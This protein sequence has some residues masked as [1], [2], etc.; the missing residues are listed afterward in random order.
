MMKQRKNDTR[1]QWLNRVATALRPTFKKHGF[2]LPPVRISTGFTSSGRRGAAA[3]EC[4][5]DK[6]DADR[7]HQIFIDPRDD[8]PVNVVNSVAHELIHAAIGLEQGH[9]GDFKKLALAIGML[10]PMTET[11]SGPEFVALAG[12]ILA[13]VGAYPHKRLECGREL[14][15][16]FAAA[17]DK[18]AKPGE[19]K[20]TK[21]GKDRPS[22]I[23]T[24]GPKPQGARLKKAHCPACGYTV[25]ITRKWIEVAVPSCPNPGCEKHGADLEVAD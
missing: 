4:W 24:S 22:T 11:P 5:T 18:P 23:I 2:P 13:K 3:A 6:L 20:P 10:E 19:T 9:K 16:L 21:P 14:G 25:R 8:E 7:R 15:D 17:P 12:K 1:E